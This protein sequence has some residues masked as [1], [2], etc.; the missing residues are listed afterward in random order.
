MI[1]VIDLAGSYEEHV[2]LLQ[3]RLEKSPEYKKKIYKV[4]HPELTPSRSINQSHADF[5]NS[6]SSNRLILGETIS[7]KENIAPNNFSKIPSRKG[8]TSLYDE[9]E[10]PQ[11]RQSSMI[12]QDLD[13]EED[14]WL[15][16]A[17]RCKE[18]KHTRFE[19]NKRI[20][21]LKRV[22]TMKDGSI[23]VIEDRIIE[24]IK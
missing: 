18:R 17:I 11:Y 9:E 12:A 22:F 21:T 20:Q 14:E 24:K 8:I 5:R 19:G 2:D 6:P 7:H 16:G 15:P 10:K 23:E 1:C 13:L 3:S 4:P